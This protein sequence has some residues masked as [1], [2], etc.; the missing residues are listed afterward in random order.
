MFLFFETQITLPGT[1]IKR[2]AIKKRGTIEKG[3]I[4]LIFTHFLKTRALISASSCL[5]YRVE[6]KSSTKT[7]QSF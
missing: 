3:N 4:L 1:T 7:E 2:K 6:V 5:L